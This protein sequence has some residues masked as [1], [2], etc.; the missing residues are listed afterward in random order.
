LLVILGFSCS[1]AKASQNSIEALRSIEP[2]L[3]ALM[4]KISRYL[5][6]ERYYEIE[7]YLD[8]L[9]TRRPMNL[10]RVPILESIYEDLGGRRGYGP[11]LEK[12]VEIRD[13]HSAYIARGILYA[14]EAWRARGQDWGYTV[15]QKHSD[16][17]RQKLKQAAVDFEKAYRINNHDPNSSARMVRVCIGLGWPR[18]DMEQWF[19]RAVTADHL[20]TQNTKFRTQIFAVARRF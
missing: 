8:D 4:E 17:Y 16:L 18:N 12:W 3:E 7:N 15:S 11:Y 1:A 20:Q 13:H 6:K 10:G 9:N 2:N 5:L 19:T 14:Q